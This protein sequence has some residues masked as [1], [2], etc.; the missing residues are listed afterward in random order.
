MS[1]KK[2]FRSQAGLEY[3]MTYGWAMIIIVA[4]MGA[5][6][7]VL[8]APKAG[9][10]PLCESRLF[11]SD[12]SAMQPACFPSKMGGSIATSKSEFVSCKSCA[13][14]KAD[15]QNPTDKLSSFT[16]FGPISPNN[17]SAANLLSLS[18]V[19]SGSYSLKASGIYGTHVYEKVL[20]KDFQVPLNSWCGKIYVNLHELSH[21]TSPTD[22]AFFGAY[23]SNNH[24]YDSTLRDLG[25][26]AYKSGTS[27]YIYMKAYYHACWAGAIGSQLFLVTNSSSGWPDEFIPVEWCITP[28]QKLFG[29]VNNGAWQAVTVVGPTKVDFKTTAV[30]WVSSYNGG[31][32]LIKSVEYYSEKCIPP[33]L[34][35]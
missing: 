5:L 8:Q 11:F 35:G 24:N 9:T 10:L 20:I 27:H 25:I 7:V 21:Y 17:G 28:R 2:N 15:W 4:V 23:T 22:L 33:Q 29:R 3:L 34:L 31:S 6:F 26:A 18:N 16:E 12:C 19:S 1:A 13:F 30:G 14:F 32:V